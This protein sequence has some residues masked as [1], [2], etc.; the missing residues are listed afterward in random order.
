MNSYLFEFSCKNIK[1]YSLLI[2][3]FC[4][5]NLLLIFP[6]YIYIYVDNSYI[7]AKFNGFYIPKYYLNF[8]HI[9]ELFQVI[10]ISSKVTILV[11]LS[12]YFFSLL[13]IVLDFYKLIFSIVAL[14][15]HTMMINSSNIF[16]YGADF[17]INF[18]LFINVFFFIFRKK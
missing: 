18:A 4:L 2:S 6:D 7:P 16:S 13:S 12:F 10:G 11:L 9:T 5:I 14:L 8:S 3:L 1:L 15:L 17:F